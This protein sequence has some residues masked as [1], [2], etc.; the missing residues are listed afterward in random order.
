MNE[1]EIKIKLKSIDYFIN[2]L[3]QLGCTLD[4]AKV[5]KDVIFIPKD[6]KEYKIT[7]GA[8]VIRTRE[9]NEASTFTLKRQSGT[10]LSSKEFNLGI[11][12]SKTLHQMLDLMGFR[13]LVRVNKTRRQ[14]IL[15]KYNICIDDVEQLGCFLELEYITD[16]ED[17]KTIQQEM[18]TYLNDLGI[19]TSNRSTVPYDTQIY[20]LNNP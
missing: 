15:G 10:N 13:E 12:N 5:Q 7:E 4:K 2:K 1:I 18:L 19:D 14:G 8:V 6:M 9:E 17:F 20:K 3:H 11:E 16:R